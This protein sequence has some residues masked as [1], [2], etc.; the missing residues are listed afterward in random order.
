MVIERFRLAEKRQQLWQQPVILWL[1]RRHPAHRE[2]RCDQRK[3]L[4]LRPEW[5]TDLHTALNLTS[6]QVFGRHQ[7]DDIGLGNN[8]TG[9]I[10]LEASGPIV[11]IMREDAPNR[12]AGYN[13]V[14]LAP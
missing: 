6:A 10:L 2:R 12:V 14:V 3:R 4:L 13:G 7:N 8:W 5:C 11:A 1:N 9:S